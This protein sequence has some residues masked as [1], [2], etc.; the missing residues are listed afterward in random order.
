MIGAFTSSLSGLDA[1]SKRFEV[2]SANIVHAFDTS[3]STRDRVSP[4]APSD[5]VR[6]YQNTFRPRDVVQTT[7]ADGGTH[8]QTRERDPA[9]VPAY[10]P[11]DPK[12]GTSGLVD[13]P[14]VDVAS[15]FVNIIFAQRAYEA[16][17]K[18]IQAREQ[19]LGVT[20][21]ARS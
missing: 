14:N 4:V 20:I 17:L 8:A 9:T 2:A 7:T 15:E 1:A 16:A 6:A 13:R 5:A 21:D 12:A 3:P 18:A 19:V 10:R 11:D